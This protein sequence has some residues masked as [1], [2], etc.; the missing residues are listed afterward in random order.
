MHLT[1]FRQGCKIRGNESN[2][3]AAS[4]LRISVYTTP[5]NEKQLS[6]SS[7]KKVL[8]LH[9]KHVQTLPLPEG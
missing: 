4:R 2:V 5:Q 8:K 9:K 1:D 3:L 6:P 7:K